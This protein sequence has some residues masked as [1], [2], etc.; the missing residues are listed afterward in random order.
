MGT[1]LT[2]LGLFAVI[3]FGKFIYDTYLTDNTERDFEEY[4]KSDPIAAAKIEKPKTQEQFTDLVNAVSDDLYIK[5]KNLSELFPDFVKG[6]TKMKKTIDTSSK[7]ELE[8]ATGDMR[9]FMTIQQKLENREFYFHATMMDKESEF[10]SSD[11]FPLGSRTAIVA[12]PPNWDKLIPEAIKNIESKKLRGKFEQTVND[13]QKSLPLRYDGYYCITNIDGSG[14][15]LVLRFYPDG[16]VIH[17]KLMGDPY[18]I[19]S[20]FK[21][22][23]DKVLQGKYSLVNGVLDFSV[24]HPQRGSSRFVGY[25]KDKTHVHLQVNGK[26]EVGFGFITVD[27][28][29]TYKPARQE[30]PD[31]E[32]FYVDFD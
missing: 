29:K 17:V 16:V 9:V 4:R 27:E 15:T 5:P 25:V 7:L 22:D 23:S 19:N 1:F 28:N 2:I 12:S 18:T 24:S 30:F 10:F 3:F 26:Q 11:K 6:L 21:R 31:K 32:D 8:S 20:W 13:E 14:A